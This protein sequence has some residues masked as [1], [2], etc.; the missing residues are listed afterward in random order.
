MPAWRS[1]PSCP[2]LCPRSRSVGGWVDRTGAQGFATEAAHAA[3][4]F[5]FVDRELDRILSIHQIGNDASERVMQKL[6][7]RLDRETIDPSCNRPTRVYAITRDEYNR[8]L[9]ITA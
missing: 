5:A 6:G 7:M 2:R 4:H 9:A 8:T 3:L 1:Q